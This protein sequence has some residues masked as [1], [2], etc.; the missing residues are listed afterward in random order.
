MA[1]S[2]LKGVAGLT[3]AHQEDPE[4][5]VFKADVPALEVGE[6]APVRVESLKL[7]AL[8]EVEQYLSASL[9]LRNSGS[10]PI[11]L[12]TTLSYDF[13]DGKG[14]PVEPW[15][16]FL[17]PVSLNIP[18]RG[19]Q[20][21]P[22]HFVAPHQDGTYS[23]VVRVGPDV[24]GDK[25]SVK[26]G[27]RRDVTSLRLVSAE[28]M[29]PLVAGQITEYRLRLRAG[30]VGGVTS[31]RPVLAALVPTDSQRPLYEVR[32]FSE[33]RLDIPAGQERE[34]VLPVVVPETMNGF[35][36]M[37]LPRDGWGRWQL[38]PPPTSSSP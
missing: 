34:V 2:K 1:A 11:K 10:Q 37:L 36:L 14:D 7:P 31:E 35:E 29:G 24:A 17:Q 26:V 19:Q 23:V 3:L 27:T 9:T 15:E 8:L 22:V 28:P 16:R 33:L 13:L 6:G 18:P 25:F 32:D 30:P 20:T 4:H 5:T 21:V 12:D 38:P